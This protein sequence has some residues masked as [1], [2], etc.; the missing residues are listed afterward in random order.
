MSKVP[1]FALR[2][3]RPLG[4]GQL[5]RVAELGDKLGQLQGPI[6]AD[7]ARHD[8]S[9]PE[10]A[11]TCNRSGVMGLGAHSAEPGCKYGMFPST[12]K[13]TVV[14]HGVMKYGH[15]P[16]GHTNENPRSIHRR[17]TDESAGEEPIIQKSDSSLNSS[18]AYSALCL[19][20]THE[21]T[22]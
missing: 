15:E 14:P 8:E 22:P 21:P 6:W 10:G 16:A 19:H 18:S 17:P 4:T 7:A 12:T 9:R 13:S 20:S 5:L 2:Q 11:G 3:M 1:F